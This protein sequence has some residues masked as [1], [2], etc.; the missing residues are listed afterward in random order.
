M[1]ENV[2]YALKIILEWGQF[3]SLEPCLKRVTLELWM[4]SQKEP[5]RGRKPSIN[6]CVVGPYRS[7]KSTLLGNLLYL[8]NQT[9][10]A[11]LHKL[12]RF[13]R[14]D[15]L[16]PEVRG[17]EKLRCLIDQRSDEIE[18]GMT[19]DISHRHFECKSH[20]VNFI[21]TP[22]RTRFVRNRVSGIFQGDH[23]ILVIE[24]ASPRSET[25][26]I[27]RLLKVVRMLSL[28]VVINKLDQ[29]C[30]EETKFND[31]KTEWTNYIQQIGIPKVTFIPVSAKHGTNIKEK[32]FSWFQGDT[33]YA[34]LENLSRPPHCGNQPLRMMIDKA[35]QVKSV[36][37]VVCGIV[38]SGLLVHGQ[39][40]KIGPINKI[41][42]VRSLHLAIPKKAIF[43]AYPGD[44]V[45]INVPGINK[46]DCAQRRFG[47]ITGCVLDEEIDLFNGGKIAY[48]AIK[49]QFSS[50][51]QSIPGVQFARK[52]APLHPCISFVALGIFFGI[53]CNL[54]LR[55][56]FELTMHCHNSQVQVKL[57]QS[58]SWRTNNFG[59]KLLANKE[60]PLPDSI[61]VFGLLNNDLFN[62]IFFLIGA[63]FV[64]KVVPLICKQMYI[65]S[66]SQ[67]LWNDFIIE[68][69]VKR[70]VGYRSIGDTRR[71]YQFYTDSIGA[72]IPSCQ[73]FIPIKKDCVAL[74]SCLPFARPLGVDTY[75]NCPKLG[76]IL[77]RQGN[78]IIAAAK[79][80]DCKYSSHTYL[81]S[82]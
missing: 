28:T 67:Q 49:P 9:S 37:T 43:K 57:D 75:A 58:I 65:R 41:A 38:I 50:Q 80:I 60:E 17:M 32:G 42:R 26:E 6:V 51:W 8:C 70:L 54:Q 24:P 66:L 19:H 40:V 77:L 15:P 5:E 45:A 73:Q 22:G 62:L 7:G 72:P 53:P 82:R 34:V 61:G 48:T 12:E 59:T 35:Y 14:T 52:E 21:N 18:S 11:Q 4:I 13:A 1:D 79:V 68:K 71:E 2:F 56:G 47:L 36:G 3:N 31:L 74:F 76:T 20:M 23:A 64:L 16:C 81:K 46:S 63:D 78:E 10:H 25:I 44:Y 27:I 69:G 33:L 39:L 55:K 29:V 30:S